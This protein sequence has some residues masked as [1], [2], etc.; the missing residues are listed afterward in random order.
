MRVSGPQRGASAS[1]GRR[2]SRFHPL[3]VRGRPRCRRPSIATAM[4]AD[5]SFAA[6]FRRCQNPLGIGRRRFERSSRLQ[7]PSTFPTARSESEPQSQDRCAMSVVRQGRDGRTG[8]PTMEPN[9]RSRPGNSP[10]S[11]PRRPVRRTQDQVATRMTIQLSS[12]HNKARAPRSAPL[13]REA[14]GKPPQPDLWHA[15]CQLES[16]TCSSNVVGVQRRD[17]GQADLSVPASSVTAN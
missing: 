3:A 12:L 11:Q 10:R 6:P 1:A 13:R 4:V 2:S 16:N 15:A 8:P 17:A 14:L 9:R 7:T 5:P